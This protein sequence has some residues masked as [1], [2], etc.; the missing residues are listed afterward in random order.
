MVNSD[1]KAEVR[2]AGIE[3]PL[4]QSGHSVRQSELYQSQLPDFDSEP[5]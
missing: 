5:R 1:T 2:E 4:R 3:N